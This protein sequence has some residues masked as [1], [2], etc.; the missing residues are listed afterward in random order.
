MNVKL[1]MDCVLRKKIVELVRGFF[2]SI[3]LGEYFYEGFCFFIY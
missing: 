2:G 1:W 3:S